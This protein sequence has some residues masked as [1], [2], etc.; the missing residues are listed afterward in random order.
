MKH[1]SKGFLLRRSLLGIVVG[2]WLLPMAL[3]LAPLVYY[4]NQSVRRQFNET[5][6]AS[7][8]NAAATC[9]RNMSIVVEKSRSAS[10]DGKIRSAFLRYKS[11]EVRQ[12]L[13]ESI[14]SYLNQN[15]RYDDNFLVTMIF[16]TEDPSYIYY[17]F[18][19]LLN[20]SYSSV[21]EY[22]RNT[23][24][25]VISVS[26]NLD[27]RIAFVNTNGNLYMVRNI[28]DSNFTP[29]AVIVSQINLDAMLGSFRNIVWET[30]AKIHFNGVAVDAL[31]NADET[32]PEGPNLSP[33]EQEVI[34]LNGK[35]LVYGRENTDAVDIRYIIEVDLQ[36][37]INGFFYFNNT[38]KVLLVLTIPLL[39]FAI[40][41]FYFNIFKPIDRLIFAAGNI[42]GGELGYQV[43]GKISNREFNYLREAFNS[44]SE[45]LKEQ[46]EHIYNEELALRDARITAL[47]S[48][49]NPH[50]LNNTL[51][52][53]NWEVRLGN[54][55]KVL[56]MIEALATMLDAAM[57]RKSSPLVTLAQEMVYVDAY[58]YIISIRFG[59]RLTVKKEINP[60]LMRNL[61]PRFIMQPI[62]ENSV[63]HGV[64]KMQSGIIE[65]CA[66]EAEGGMILSIRNNSPM[67]E[68]DILTVEHLLSPDYN[69]KGEGYLHLG[70]Y[71]VNLRL[72]MIYGEKSALKITSDGESTLATFFI[73]VP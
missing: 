19:P 44:M 31:S 65:I 28:V 14:S 37:F 57:D 4:T 41:F 29:F 59:K 21:T 43:E 33:G 32:W 53:I 38:V 27:T 58:L 36:G 66:E 16:L 11:T 63:E 60:S 72:K 62:I 13:Y 8:L 5:V 2:C 49:I 71:N 7:I 26:K 70:I 1:K 15:Y 68:K 69:A 45:R 39:A 46:F 12:A 18:N 23:H 22:Q 3:T 40:L 24:D 17:T 35:S 34:N 10:Y 55:A 42:Q 52:I 61:V 51:E 50:F 67:T 30:G 47:Q 6:R 9:R 73:S 64:S 56:N 48:Q 20:A 25:N 54:N